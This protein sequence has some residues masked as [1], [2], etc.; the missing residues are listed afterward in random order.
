MSDENDRH[1]PYPPDVKFKGWRLELD[2]EQVAQSDTW[3]LA[4]PSQRPWL[5]MLWAV[6][7]QQVPCGSMPDD[8]ELVAAKLGLKEEEFKTMKRSLFRGWW[9]ASDGRLYQETLTSRVLDMIDKRESAKG[10]KTK[11]RISQAGDGAKKPA[12]PKAKPANPTNDPAETLNPFALLDDAGKDELWSAGRSILEQAKV[13]ARQVGSFL[14]GLVRDYGEQASLDAVRAAVRERPAD[15]VGYM[16][17]TCMH[18]VGSRR[19]SN[20]QSALESRNTA[21]ALAW[22][23]GDNHDD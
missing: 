22:A 2:M 19:G 11:S 14:G 21:A 4:K 9:L 10:R 8:D 16:K 6:A 3:A 12:K 7:W 15:P 18:A 13:P 1:P 5:L 20:K 17:A 23:E